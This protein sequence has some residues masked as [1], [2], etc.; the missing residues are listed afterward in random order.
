MIKD[1]FKPIVDRRARVLVLGTFPSEESLK[2]NRYYAH[3]RNQFW[4]MMAAL[5]GTGTVDDYEKRCD[6]V[7][8]EGIAIWDVL[9]SCERE[10]SSDGRIRRGHFIF[11]DIAGFLSE[12]PVKAIFFNGTKA[13]ALFKMYVNT[14]MLPSQPLLVTLPSTSPAHAALSK[15]QKLE[16][17]LEVKTYL[18]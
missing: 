7:K 5:C 8:G 4:E 14:A 18:A 15:Q 12:Y 17:W 6:L 16:R 11:N 9:N 13:A 10:G 1:G 2:Q 3:L